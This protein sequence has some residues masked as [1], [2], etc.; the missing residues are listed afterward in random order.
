M[1][2]GRFTVNI[3]F[4]LGYLVLVSLLTVGF[5]VG[6]TWLY[7]KADKDLRDIITYGSTLMGATAG[8]LLVLYTAENIRNSNRDKA[9]AAASRFV[10]RWN[11]PEFFAL[12]KAWRAISDELEGLTPEG[13]FNCLN[14]NAEKRVTAVEV[15][16]FFEEM[17]IAVNMEFADEEIIERFF[18]DILLKYFD[19]YQYWIEQH[20]A[21]RKFPSF[22][23]EL[24]EVVRKWKRPE[25]R[26][27]FRP[28]CFS[29]NCVALRV[30]PA[31]FPLVDV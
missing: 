24:A 18:R 2:S 29:T 11:D 21:A 17:A 28:P 15:F 3:K 27:T 1:K 20:R 6:L 16:N 30:R 7:A 26:T 12:K 10:Q 14:D 13:R 8:L 25:R 31:E 4:S 23:S 9:S 19:H 5:V 22:C